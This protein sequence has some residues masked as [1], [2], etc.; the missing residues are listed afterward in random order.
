MSA[1]AVETP[2]DSVVTL[3]EAA[4]RQIAVMLTEDN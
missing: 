4:A 2:T 1:S 3:T